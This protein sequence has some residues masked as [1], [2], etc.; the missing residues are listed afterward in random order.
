MLSR[1]VAGWLK[2]V[3]YSL[4]EDTMPICVRH[5]VPYSALSINSYLSLSDIDIRV[6]T[7]DLF[8][9]EEMT[10]LID[11][12]VSVVVG[13]LCGGSGVALIASGIQGIVIGFIVSALV[14]ALGKDQM[15]GAFLK[16]NIPKPAR[17]LMP[18]SYLKS[19][20]DRISA[21]VKKS[22]YEKLEKEKNAEITERL[23]REIS[24]QIEL[25]LTKMAEVVEIP[26]G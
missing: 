20:A 18:K 24:E 11:A 2:T 14:L 7:K 12:I 6:E 8:A 26:L 9:V 3:S 16:M 5:N 25:C 17:K 4:E 22:L 15:Q 21:E 13:L 1:T 10:W 23:V 19:R